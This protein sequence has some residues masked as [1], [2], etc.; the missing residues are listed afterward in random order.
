MI[1]RLKRDGLNI[2]GLIVGKPHSKRSKFAADLKALVRDL[3]LEQDIIFIPH[4][5][6]IKEIMAISDI[7]YSL[8]NLPEAF[9]RVSLEA[10]ALGIPV[11]AYQH[12]G[13]EEQLS[14]AF[15][16]GL[17]PPGDVS[18]ATDRTKEILSHQLK[19]SITADFT[20]EKMLMATLKVYEQIIQS[21]RK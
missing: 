6:D 5:S 16:Q 8:S 15:P 13:V 14:V 7:V 17:V 21:P 3:H 9:G 2:C 12:G 20:L 19:P 10:I 1:S 11:I 4:R 18:A